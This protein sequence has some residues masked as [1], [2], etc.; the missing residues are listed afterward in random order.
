MLKILFTVDALI[1]AGTERSMLDL[2]PHFSKEV[3][4]KVVYFYP[5]HDLK[6]EYEAANVPLIYVGLPGKLNLIE[7]V[8][9]LKKI[10]QK[11]Q[12]DLVISSLLRANLISR[13]ACKLTKTILIGTFVSDSYSEQRSASFSFKRKL[14][15]TYYYWLDRLTAG[16]PKAWI[17]NSESIK[18]SNCKVLKIKEKKVKVIYRGRAVEQFSEW[19]IPQND[20]F[21]FATVGRLFETKGFVDL[22][23]AFNKLYQTHSK[24]QLAIYGE[25]PFR[26]KL[27][28]LIADLKLQN[29]ITLHGNVKNAWQQL[30]NANCFVFP[31]WYEGFSGALVEAMMTGI[32]IIASN[33]PMNLEAIVADKTALVHQVKDAESIY[34]KMLVCFSNYDQMIA[35]GKDARTEALNKFDIKKIAA[36]YEQFLNTQL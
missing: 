10:I 24:I 18:H 30:Y 14:G 27:T 8:K 3:E 16:I 13:I 15:A 1:N 19:K 17:S 23:T 5:R 36:Q 29:N 6:P 26:N 33:I 7:G 28:K 12:P 20:S 4:L 11:E 31:S 34:Q 22:I 35:M 25:G 32:P 2:V 21:T 9:Q